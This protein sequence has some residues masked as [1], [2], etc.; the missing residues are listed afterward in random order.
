MEQ[1]SIHL[2]GYL[3]HEP[4]TSITNLI[5]SICCLLFGFKVGKS[6]AKYWS[7]FFYCISIAT[8]F[9]T[10][11]HGFFTDKNNILQLISRIANIT[12]VYV[13]SFAS[14]L[15]LKNKKVINFL[16]TVS[17][18]QLITALVL[19]ITINRFWIVVWDAIFGLGLLVAAIHIHLI[20]KG[21]K[22]SRF[23]LAGVVVNSF[24]TI[25]YSNKISISKWF[26]HNDIG[27][28]ILFIGFYLMA[29]GAIKLQDYAST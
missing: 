25:I 5:L 13:C 8:L 11:G 16:K 9:A 21:N 28:A 19:I 23:I 27:H 10:L 3:F 14:I 26:N 15:F 4:V 6:Y 20:Y 17:F 7:Y 24:T 1:P 22:G 2:F 12:G 29:I 18:V